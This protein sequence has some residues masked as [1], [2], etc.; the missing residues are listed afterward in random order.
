MI[1]GEVS[2]QVEAALKAVPTLRK[3]LVQPEEDG[4]ALKKQFESLPPGQKLKAAL[5]MQQK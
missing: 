1:A 2:K 4:A 3:G 5:A